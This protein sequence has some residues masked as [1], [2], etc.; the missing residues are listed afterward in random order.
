MKINK[1]KYR[2]IVLT[3]SLLYVNFFIF[4]PYFH[5]HHPENEIVPGESEI[6]YS[7]VFNDCCDEA[8]EGHLDDNSHHSHQH[9]ICNVNNIIPT[10]TFQLTVEIDFYSTFNYLIED[11]D[12]TEFENPANDSFHLLQWELLVHSATNVSPPLS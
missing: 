3:L 6:I 4:A 10:R 9:G 12:K 1:T 8:A 11:D 7:H 2:I 5:H